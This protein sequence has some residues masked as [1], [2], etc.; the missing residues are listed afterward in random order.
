M[1]GA[2]ELGLGDSVK[3]QYCSSEA[4]RLG[5]R[6]EP[7]THEGPREKRKRADWIPRVKGA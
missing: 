5:S 3:G 6:A 2:A 1:C 7:G 4:P